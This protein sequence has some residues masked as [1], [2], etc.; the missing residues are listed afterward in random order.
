MIV[1]NAR[2]GSHFLGRTRCSCETADPQR[3]FSGHIEIGGFDVSERRDLILYAAIKRGTMRPRSIADE[4]GGMTAP[5]ATMSLTSINPYLA[6]LLAGAIGVAQSASANDNTLAYAKELYAS[7]AYDEALVVLDRLQSTA[8]ATETT[9][10]AEYRVFCLLALDRRDEARQNIEGILHDDPLYLPSGDQ[11]SPRIQSIF[12]DVRRQ[13]LPKIVMEQ[14]A[15]AKAAFERKDAR[16]EQQFNQVL[17]LLDDPDVQGVPALRDLRTV[18]SAFSDLTKAMAAAQAQ[19]PAV[20]GPAQPPPAQGAV[21]PPPAAQAATESTPPPD[22]IY[23]SA[24]ADVVPP[25]AQL[26]PMP[27]WIPPTPAVARQDFRGALEVLVDERGTVVSAA[28]RAGL[29]PAYNELLLRAARGWK[30]APAQRKGIP[31]RYLKVIDIHLRPT[32]PS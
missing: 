24:N 23:T 6:L 25:V 22:A 14:Y 8:P 11:A 2:D 10:I 15:A 1:R 18:V 17:A 16:A 13:S 29:H 28:L 7:A 30:Y 20:K 27:L 32:P 21:R 19:P 12:R 4:S 9:S 26:Q 5:G 31:V 3:S